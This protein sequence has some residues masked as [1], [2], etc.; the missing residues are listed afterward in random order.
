MSPS[1]IGY[2]SIATPGSVAG[3]VYA[4][5]KYGKLGLKR[6]MAP[7]I[8]LG[9]RWIRTHPEE[10]HELTDS[11][12]AHFPRLAHLPARRPTL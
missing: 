9:T 7:A 1:I 12:L 2:R 8:K 6:V 5:R 3:L 11:D 10:A 4:E